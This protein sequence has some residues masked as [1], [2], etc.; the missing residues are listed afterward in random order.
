MES[1]HDNHEGQELETDTASGT[2]P[3]GRWSASELFQKIS[4]ELVGTLEF[5]EITAIVCRAARDLTGADGASFVI[6]EEE[7]VF[8][9]DENA[10]EPLWKG[11][12]F[13]IKSCISGISMSTRKAIAI[14][15]VYADERV[16]I[17]AYRTT[18]VQSMA[19]MPI[20]PE[21]PIGAIGVYWKNRHAATRAELNRLQSLAGLADLAI[22]NARTYEEAVTARRHAEQMS[23][24]KDEFL[25]TVSHE[26]RSPLNAVLGWASLLRNSKTSSTVDHQTALAVIERNAKALGRLVEDLLDVS[27]M[28]SGKLRLDI[29]TH[30]LF[31]IIQQTVENFRPA[32][33]AKNISIQLKSD[34]NETPVRADAQRIQQ[35]V[36]NL[37]SNAVKFTPEGG[38]IDISVKRAE[39]H[40]EIDVADNGRGIN[41]DF[42]PFVFDRFR[43]AERVTIG[44]RAGLGLGLTIVKSLAEAHGGEVFASSDGEG[45]GATF[46]VRMPIASG[47]S[48]DFDITQAERLPISES[49]LDGLRILIVDDDPDVCD[50]V[51]AILEERGASVLA[52]S[53]AMLAMEIFQSDKPD[54]IIS[55]ITMPEEDGYQFIRRLRY[56]ERQQG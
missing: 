39:S 1:F 4:R 52:A 56:F 19:M 41:E 42:L 49:R 5:A 45:T 26:L 6:H 48:P 20:G 31:R 7:Q 54:I 25:A 27:H 37:L 15:D 40:Y 3:E 38:R 12:R 9:A 8:Y 14:E 24:L 23:Q 28:D 51:R 21:T 18:F 50:I 46:T 11:Q 32:A 10:I 13:P 44:P 22:L 35:I 29:E 34:A 36:F 30:N 33:E 47:E 2:E 17:E 55:D 53:S 16:P 43:Q